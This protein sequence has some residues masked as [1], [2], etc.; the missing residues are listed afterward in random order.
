MTP[1]GHTGPPR[2]LHL[3]TSN[4]GGSGDYTCT[5]G[6]LK[7]DSATIA[8]ADVATCC[9][10][11]V[12]CDE[13]TAATSTCTSCGQDLYTLTT[14]AANA[15]AACVGSFILCGNG[16]GDDPLVCGMCSGKTGGSG[17]Y[18]CTAGTLKTDSATI[19]G[20]DD[21][22]CCDAPVSSPPAPPAVM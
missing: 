11:P 13:A 7:A 14:A 6:T 10:A 1:W 16:D 9:D 21:A 8:G 20:A 18:T 15:G 4:T 22:T 17:D 5:A 12:D 3:H 2:W 19:A